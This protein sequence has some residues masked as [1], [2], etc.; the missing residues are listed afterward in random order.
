MRGASG[1]KI[2]VIWT[3]FHCG[4]ASAPL[5]QAHL[6]L[7]QTVGIRNECLVILEIS[8][9]YFEEKLCGDCWFVAEKKVQ[10]GTG[11]F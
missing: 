4:A 7:K 2:K 5:R 3:I 6:R 8:W 9:K 1:G 11:F 10:F